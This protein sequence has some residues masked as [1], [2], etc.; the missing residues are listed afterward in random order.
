MRLSCGC[1][2][3]NATPEGIKLK[4]MAPP[5]AKKFLVD[6]SL[7]PQTHRRHDER[8]S[9]TGAIVTCCASLGVDRPRSRPCRS[10]GAE[11]KPVTK[12]LLGASID[13]LCSVALKRVT[14]S[15]SRAKRRPFSYCE[16]ENIALAQRRLNIL[17]RVKGAMYSRGACHPDLRGHVYLSS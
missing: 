3:R 15:I 2:Q 14:C 7:S 10:A 9:K 5:E 17:R 11:I 4:Y 12:F 8:D 16:I 6:W 1:S 13:L